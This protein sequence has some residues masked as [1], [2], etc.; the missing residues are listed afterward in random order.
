MIGGSEARE[1]YESIE[2]QGTLAPPGELPLAVLVPGGC[3]TGRSCRGGHPNLRNPPLFS[4]SHAAR[5]VACPRRVLPSSVLRL[6]GIAHALSL[7]ETSTL[8]AAGR[9]GTTQRLRS[10]R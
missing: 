9:R 6:A 5:C 1:S 7:V 3:S 10:S 8:C 4:A 2:H